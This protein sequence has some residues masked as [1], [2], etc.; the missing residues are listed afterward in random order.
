MAEGAEGMMA[1]VGSKLYQQMA[2]E[3][4]LAKPLSYKEGP[5]G[6]TI[7]RDEQAEGFNMAVAAIA[8]TLGENNPRFDHDRFLHAV[9]TGTDRRS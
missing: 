9:L 2:R 8:I 3:L 4:Y 6:S 1:T 5:H 7:M